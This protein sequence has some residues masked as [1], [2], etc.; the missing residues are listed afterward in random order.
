[1]LREHGIRFREDDVPSAAGWFT[2]P[3]TRAR[4]RLDSTAT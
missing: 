1:V 3:A 2:Q 4:P